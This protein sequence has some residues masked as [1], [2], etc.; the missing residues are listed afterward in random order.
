MKGKIFFAELALGKLKLL[1]FFKGT[2]KG[3]IPFYVKIFLFVGFKSLSLNR[4]DYR[5]SMNFGLSNI[6]LSLLFAFSDKIRV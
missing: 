6:L 3:Q 5:S 2:L 1:C 4:P